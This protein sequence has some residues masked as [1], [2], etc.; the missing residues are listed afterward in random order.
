MQVYSPIGRTRT[1]PKATDDICRMRIAYFSCSDLTQGYFTAYGWAA[2]F[3]SCLS[4]GLV[5]DPSAGAVDGD[6]RHLQAD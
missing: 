6:G 2:A 4:F 5:V 3:V 1:I